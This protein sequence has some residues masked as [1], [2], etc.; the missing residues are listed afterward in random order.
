M[1]LSTRSVLS[2]AALALAI[3]NFGR[4][5]F[6]ELGGRPGA[7][8]LLD[9]VLLPLWVLLLPTLASGARRWRL[10]GVSGGLLCFL[11]VA[12]ISTALAGPRWGLG[13][14]AWLSSAAFLVRWALYAGYFVLLVS[15]P[16]AEREG[17]VVWARFERVFLVMAGFGLLQVAVFPDL[18][19]RMAEV[20]GIPADPQGRRLVSTLFDPQ[21]MGGLL[22]LALLFQLARV[23]EALP[24]RR[25]PLALLATALLLTVSRSAILGFAVGLLGIVVVR[26][27]GRELRRLA[28]AGG[29]LLL[30]LLP[31]LLDFAVSFNKLREDG[32][33]VQRLIP[34]LRGLTLV[35]D[36]PLLGVGFNAAGHA[37]R[38]YGWV[39]IGGSDVTMDGGLLFIAVMTGGLGLAAFVSML[40]ALWRTARRTW[41]STTAAPD[42]RAFA[43]GTVAATAAIVAQSFF[44]STL[45]TPWMMLPLWVAWARVVRA[46]PVTAPAPAAAGRRRRT[47]ARWVASGGAAIL[48]LAAGGCEPC[49][50]LADCTVAER[51]VLTG[52]ILSRAT[53]KPLR[54][55]SVQAEGRAALTNAAG[56]WI[57]ELPPGDSLVN[58][59]VGGD[60]GYIATGVRARS[61]R[62]SGD[63]TELGVWYDQPFFQFI[64]G[65]DYRGALLPGVSGRFVIDSALGGQTIV[66]VP[67]GGGYHRFSGPAPRPGAVPGTLTLSVDGRGTWVLPNLSLEAEYA[68]RIATVRGTIHLAKAYQYGGNVVDRGTFESSPGTLIT[69]TRTAGLELDA[70]VSA[71]A[72]E[73]GFFTF[74]IVPRGRGRVIGDLSFAPPNGRPAYVYRNVA[75][76]TYE[77]GEVPY[78]GLFAHGERWDWV[79]EVRR[80]ADSSAVAWTPFEFVRTG[81]LRPEAGDTIRGSSNGSGRLLIRSSVRDTGTVTGVL[82]M[83]PEGRAPVPVGTF[84]L[85]TFAAD[86]QYF[87]G[88]RFVPLLRSFRYGGNVVDRGTFESSPGTLITFTRTAGLELDAPVS[89]VARELGFFT[90]DI[91]PRGRGRVIGDLSFAPPNGRPAYVYRNVALETYESGEVPYLGLFAHGERWDWVVEVRR[92]ADSSAVAWTPFEF[93]RTGGLRPEAGDTIRGSSNG[94]GRLLIRSSVRDT[95]TVTGVLTMRPEGRAPVPV[96]TFGLRTFA[97]DSQ[98]FAGLRFIPFP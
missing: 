50:G 2:A 21:H 37:Q 85:R 89:A 7:V 66:S 39:A 30:P 33:A 48:L 8:S 98:Y 97:A 52:T 75:L 17:D 51:R 80:A 35:R 77:S 57:I 46:A 91:V 42:V 28:L 76:E 4:I 1:R 5:P 84:G 95:G 79:V 32:S 11:V 25:L 14:A 55:L 31:A 62:V 94:S 60:S 9:L 40:W 54:G 27:V 71:V 64:V 74:D 16:D 63:A 49:A 83:R 69:F 65:F 88:L 45:L 13:A 41:S 81:G 24:V 18:G 43:V 26:G 34:W 61:V 72:R 12:A 3:G 56:R 59:V 36:F 68:L 15:E 86:S 87:A 93:V 96:G 20:T 22:V 78:L 44:T 6:I 53:N 70:P 23:A 29:L 82:T 92:A 73:L 47:A 38:A 19:A 10:D 58:V 90:F 67:E